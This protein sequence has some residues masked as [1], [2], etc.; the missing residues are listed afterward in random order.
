MWKGIPKIRLVT[1]SIRCIL[2]L[3]ENEIDG[4]VFITLKCIDLCELPFHKRDVAAVK[5]DNLNQTLAH[6]S[7]DL[8]SPYDTFGDKTLVVN[9]SEICSA[10]TVLHRV[11]I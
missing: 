1:N 4:L 8:L 6:D 5:I 11:D 2:I 10:Y 7:W 3:Y 9:S